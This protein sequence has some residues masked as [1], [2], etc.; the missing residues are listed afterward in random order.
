VFCGII[1]LPLEGWLLRIRNLLLGLLNPFYLWEGSPR[2]W[3]HLLKP[4]SEAQ[5]SSFISGPQSAENRTVSRKLG[6]GCCL[7]LSSFRRTIWHRLKT[8]CGEDFP[9]ELSGMWVEEV[10]R[11]EVTCFMHS[12]FWGLFAK[13]EIVG[14]L[15][16]RTGSGGKM[17]C[18]FVSEFACSPFSI[19]APLT[20]FSMKM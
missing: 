16:A 18:D 12:A 14:S 4:E 13:R 19:V 7:N 11:W 2:H 3:I 15:L 17:L 5:V 9:W 6:E 10:F 20:L 1:I 8:H